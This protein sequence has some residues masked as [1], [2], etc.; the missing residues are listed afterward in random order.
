MSS[1]PAQHQTSRELAER[2]AAWR[3]A[4]T[5]AQLR[6]IEQ[7]IATLVDEGL[8]REALAPGDTAPDFI[9]ADSAGRPTRLKDLLRHG[10]VVLVFYRGGWCGFC[11][12]YLRGLQR[13]LPEIRAAGAELVAISPQ[14]P[15]PALAF[16]TREDL[17]FPLLCDLG[18]KVST[19]FGLTYPLPGR[20]RQVYRQ[21]GIDL[22]QA[23]G[24]AGD[25]QLPLAATYLINPDRTIRAASIDED[26]ARRLDPAE[27]VRLLRQG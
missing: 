5:P 12:T 18:L 20:V 4:V 13:A 26:P 14:L 22:A 27:I 3:K 7:L 24:P 2:A 17:A 21:F 10:P 15:D 23:N 9:L 19:R 11:E 8:A 16:E 25:G 6:T 1:T